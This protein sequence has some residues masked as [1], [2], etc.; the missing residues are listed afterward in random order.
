M[1]IINRLFCATAAVA[2]ASATVLVAASPANAHDA[3]VTAEEVAAILRENPEIVME[4]MQLAQQKQREMETQALA[5]RV[6][7]VASTI[8]AGDKQV[9]FVGPEDGT[10]IIEFFDYNCGF[11]KRFSAETAK[12][13]V[14]EGKTKIFLVHTPILGEG[15]VRMA[16]LAAAA[17]LQGKFAPAHNFL[18]ENGAKT[19]AEADALIPQL[20]AAAG[21]D[22]RKFDKALADGSAKAQ[23][24]HN[25]ALAEKAGVAGTPMVYANGQAIPGAIPLGP[26]KQILG[27]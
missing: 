14:A 16:E 8:F 9:A 25:A 7:P 22:K 19:A 27:S 15:S 4:A 13:L 6:A 24:D 3:G 26:L 17:N 18:I 5:A 1:K 11:C 20:I 21:L 2:C 12:P 10:A 23:A